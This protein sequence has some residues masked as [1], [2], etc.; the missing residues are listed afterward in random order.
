MVI[1]VGFEGSANKFGCSLQQLRCAQVEQVQAF[2]IFL[3]VARR[4]ATWISRNVFTS[5]LILDSCLHA[6][7]DLRL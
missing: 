6:S 5:Y 7:E 4:S 3:G 1:V 2:S